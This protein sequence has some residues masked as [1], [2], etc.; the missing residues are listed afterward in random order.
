LQQINL[1]IMKYFL[2][3]L[4]MISTSL[5]AQ[6]NNQTVLLNEGFESGTIPTE[7]ILIDADGDGNQWEM[8][9]SNWSDAHSGQ[10]SIASY[11]WFNGNVY[12]PDNWLITPE[13]EL[14]SNGV[15]KFYIKAIS[16][17]YS[18]E[19]F[20]VRISTNGTDISNFSDIVLDES[21]PEGNNEWLYKEVNLSAFNNESVNIAFVHNQSTNLFALKI[22]DVSV[23]SDTSSVGF[24][25]QFGSLSNVYPNPA[26]DIINIQA[27][28]DISQCVLYNIIGRQV[29][30]MTNCG[31]KTT[32]NTVGFDKGQYIL[33]IQT[34]KNTER[35]KIIIQ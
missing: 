18:Q 20:Q 2:P 8:H 27:K 1:Q 13:I 34:D 30:K 28:T 33:V 16:E 23:E 9:P 25:D 35:H 32:I 6:Q 12:T 19:H 11:S 7:W 26:I 24:S 10:Y 5:I 4:L 15:L 29:L 22:D 21:L 17:N 3:L 31:N 14:G